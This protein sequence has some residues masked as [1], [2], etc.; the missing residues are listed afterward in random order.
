MYDQ[1]QSLKRQAD[2]TWKE[3]ERYLEVARTEIMG[4][5]QAGPPQPLYVAH[6]GAPCSP[7]VYAACLQQSH[8][9]FSLPSS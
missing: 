8:P 1:R 4:A 6:D 5:A 3:A 2:T 9:V 7:A